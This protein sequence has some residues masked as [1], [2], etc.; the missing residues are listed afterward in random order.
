MRPSPD[1]TAPGGPSEPRAEGSGRKRPPLHGGW[2]K[3]RL[4]LALFLTLVFSV[5][6]LLIGFYLVQEVLAG[7]P[8]Q[9]APGE[10]ALEIVA[11]VV[12][13][14]GSSAMFTGI[15]AIVGASGMLYWITRR[16]RFSI[17]PDGAMTM[18]A[19]AGAGALTIAIPGLVADPELANFGLLAFAAI[20]GA[21]A[22]VFAS[23]TAWVW[24]RNRAA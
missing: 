5:P 1:L 21:L 4:W 15:P 12:W 11:G 22:A 7:N 16:G 18:V 8:L 23:V 14:A 20:W 10:L 17:W 3:A 9:R 2:A 19:G 13:M 24:M 6:A